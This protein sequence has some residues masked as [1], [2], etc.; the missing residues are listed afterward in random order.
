MSLGTAVHESI[1]GLA[2]YKAEDRQKMLDSLENILEENWKIP[3]KLAD[4][5]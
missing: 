1:E 5:K 3:E 2:K 4:L